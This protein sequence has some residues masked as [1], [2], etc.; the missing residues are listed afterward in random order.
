MTGVQTCALPIL[1]KNIDYIQDN[2]YPTLGWMDCFMCVYYLLCG[3]PLA[4]N[5]NLFNNFPTKIPL[6]MST[7]PPG[8]EIIHNFKDY[9][10]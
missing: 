1:L 3:K 7:V 10:D 8:T 9:Y 6:D 5:H 4:Q 2:I